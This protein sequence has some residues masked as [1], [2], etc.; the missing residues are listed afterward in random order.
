[1]SIKCLQQDVMQVIYWQDT[2][3][4]QGR[5]HGSKTSTTRKIKFYIL[6]ENRVMSMFSNLIEGEQV[7]IILKCLGLVSFK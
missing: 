5:R 3:T 6:Q 1:M 2:S 7:E 4:N